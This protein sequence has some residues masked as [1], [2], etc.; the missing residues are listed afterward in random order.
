MSKYTFPA[1]LKWAEED[2]SYEV[3]FPDVNGCATAGAD[4]TEALENAKDTLNLMLWGMEHDGEVIPS[5]T[6]PNAL[7][8]KHGEFSSLVVADTV[9]YQEVIDRENNP[10]KYVRQKAGLNI[11][12][13]AELLHAP[14]RTVQDW[15]SGKRMPPK[16]LQALIVEKIEAAG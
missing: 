1:V 9:A 6:A 13:L 5:P 12:G 2:K 4:L 11:K 7:E 15:N 8:L 16:W 14:Y 10:I 3:Y